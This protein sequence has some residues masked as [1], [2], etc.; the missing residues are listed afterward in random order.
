MHRIA[1][2][3]ALTS[4]L[5]LASAFIAYEGG[6]FQVPSSPGHVKLAPAEGGGVLLPSSKD[7]IMDPPTG[8]SVML[9]STKSNTVAVPRPGSPAVP[10]PAA[11]KANPDVLLFGTKSGGVTGPVTAAPTM[12]FAYKAVPLDTILADFSKAFGVSIVKSAVITNHFSM[13]SPPQTYAQALE[14]IRAML[15]VLSWT[16]D[17]TKSPDGRVV[18]RITPFENKPPAEILPSSKSMMIGAPLST[19][20]APANAPAAPSNKP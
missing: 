3:A 9:S 4:S 13:E 7:E 20:K 6:C 18:L 2:S 11:A 15:R 12:A 17:E 19:S 10:A 5:L 14:T 8:K 1:K 16:L